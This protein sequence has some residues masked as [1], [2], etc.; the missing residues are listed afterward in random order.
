MYLGTSILAKSIM[1]QREY[2]LSREQQ[3]Y[4]SAF[5]PSKHKMK[6]RA[7][8]NMGWPM[9]TPPVA[10]R[11]RSAAKS[12]IYLFFEITEAKSLPLSIN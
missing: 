1:D 2:V 5:N 9:S 8:P 12:D 10:A 11:V 6:Q 3:T 4:V 7:N